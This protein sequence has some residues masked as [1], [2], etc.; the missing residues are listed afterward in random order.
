[1]VGIRYDALF[2]LDAG[3]VR[4]G[5]GRGLADGGRRIFLQRGL[6]RANQLEIAREIRFF[7]QRRKAAVSVADYAFR[8]GLAPFCGLFRAFGMRVRMTYS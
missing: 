7:A 4:V 2:H 8:R 1:M 3:E 6:D 5:L